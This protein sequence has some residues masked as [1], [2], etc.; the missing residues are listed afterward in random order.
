MVLPMET[1]V[2]MEFDSGHPA[3]EHAAEPVGLLG[4]QK[5]TMATIVHHDRQPIH[6]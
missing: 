4:F 5:R 2:G 3:S 6:G 1:L